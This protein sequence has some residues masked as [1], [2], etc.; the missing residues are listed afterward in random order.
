MS[1]YHPSA[2]S[3]GV[4]V[5]L[6]RQF[7]MFA[8]ERFFHSISALGGMHPLA[9]P[10]RHG[11]QVTRDIA[12][13]GT[14]KLDVWQP[15]EPRGAVM[16]VHG[17]GFRI[18]SKETHWVMALMF[19]RAGYTVFNIDYRLARKH[20]FP[21]A[22]ED[23][24]RAMLWVFDHAKDFGA[25]AQLALAGESA[26]GNLI[27]GLAIASC[28]ERREP[29]ARAVFER[30]VVPAAVLPACGFLQVTEPE[31]FARRWPHISTAV[32]DQIVL[33]SHDY[34]RTA[35]T[36]PREM[37]DFA[38]PLVLL[39]RDDE[40]ARALPPFLV[41]CG[42]RDPLLDDARRL[43]HALERRGVRSE[44]HLYPGELHAFQAAMVT[45]N[46]RRFW[47]DTYRFLESVSN[48]HI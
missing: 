11:V 26:G 46:A 1:D 36:W 9:R 31:R 21:A 40:P 17:G 45:P 12:Y 6:R 7:T 33:I 2:L 22:V 8:M 35:H 10:H 48:D 39:E 44:L 23:V 43:H 37:M 14:L 25:D 15:K 28:F 30:G 27:T 4:A 18:L 3:M 16:Y 20:P 41:T 42:T 24:A 47:R 32:N 38:D 19:S 5:Q 13:D 29:W 34:L